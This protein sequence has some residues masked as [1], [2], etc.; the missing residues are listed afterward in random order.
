MTADV[1]TD[2][3]A[4]TNAIAVSISRRNLMLVNELDGGDGGDG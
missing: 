3:L 2:L 1:S 4:A